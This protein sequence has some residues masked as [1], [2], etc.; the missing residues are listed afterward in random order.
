[1]MSDDIE[2]NCSSIIEMDSPHRRGAH[3]DPNNLNN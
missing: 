1:M 2:D 3:Y